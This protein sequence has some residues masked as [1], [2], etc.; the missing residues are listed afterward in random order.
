MFGYGCNNLWN[1]NMFSF[2]G[3]GCYGGSDMSV[4]AQLGFAGVNVGMNILGMILSGTG[5]SEGRGGAGDVGVTGGKTIEEQIQELETKKSEAETKVAAE[6]D[7][8]I[9]NCQNA[10]ARANARASELPTLIAN[11]AADRDKF[12]CNGQVPPNGDPNYVHYNNFNNKVEKLQAELDKLD[13]KAEQEGSIQYLE[14][15]EKEAIQAKEKALKEVRTQ[16]DTKIQ[17][18]QDK[19]NNQGSGSF[20]VDMN[21]ILDDADGNWIQRAKGGINGDM[22]SAIRELRKA[23]NNCKPGEEMNTA[24]VGNAAKKFF[25]IYDN[26]TNKQLAKIPSDIQR[27]VP[28]IE[29]YRNATTD[30]NQGNTSASGGGTLNVRSLSGSKP[31]QTPNNGYGLGGRAAAQNIKTDILRG[32]RNFT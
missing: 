6:H 3:M 7:A 30:K 19:H 10:V 15:K 8:V 16:Y 23:L 4:G 26:L 32:I 17:A 11:A 1:T 25:G 5:S 18:L 2:P 9:T 12:L 29:K 13:G 22:R 21:E 27:A 14:E 20:T 24:A 28:Y 31:Q